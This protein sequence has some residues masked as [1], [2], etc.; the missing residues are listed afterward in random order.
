MLAKV[1]SYRKG[2]VKA[3]FVNPVSAS[4]LGKALGMTHRAPQVAFA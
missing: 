3:E 1:V 2:T 4:R